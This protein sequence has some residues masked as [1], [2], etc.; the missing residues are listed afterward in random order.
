MNKLSNSQ[1]YKCTSND[2]MK[3][4]NVSIFFIIKTN[5]NIIYSQFILISFMSHMYMY[6]TSF[7]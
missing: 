2:T 6:D 1:I 7:N 5:I 3:T 4:I